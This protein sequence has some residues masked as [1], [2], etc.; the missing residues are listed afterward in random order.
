[1]RR[2]SLGVIPLALLVAAAAF[3]RELTV[4]P[5][6]ALAEGAAPSAIREAVPAPGV[7]VA[8]DGAAIAELWL[9]REVAQDATEKAKLGVSY[10]SFREGALVGIVRFPDRWTDYAGKSV[11]AGTY[12]MRYSVQPADGNHMGVSEFRDFLLLVPVAA[13]P[14]TAVIEGRKELYDASRR[15]TGG[16]THPAVLSLLPPPKEAKAPSV[17]PLAKDGV[18]VMVEAGGRPLGLV[19][20][21]Q[22]D[23]DGY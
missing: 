6:A 19:V 16:T 12:A 5:I 1:M 21:G 14:A 17:S 15:A 20:R 2:R 10:P 8:A 23:P 22:A 11:P 18:L 7:R 4:E 3:A 13:D 9:R